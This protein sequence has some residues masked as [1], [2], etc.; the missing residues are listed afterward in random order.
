MFWKRNRLFHFDND[1]RDYC[2]D[3]KTYF[4]VG[5][6]RIYIT[7]KS[8]TINK[9]RNVKDRLKTKK[10]KHQLRD[11]KYKDKNILKNIDTI[12]KIKKKF[13]EGLISEDNIILFCIGLYQFTRPCNL[14]ESHYYQESLR[15]GRIK[16]LGIYLERF[17][18]NF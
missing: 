6:D 11:V 3:N 18:K 17:L 16:M 7:K 2:H 9:I 8:D 15:V 1:L 5:G 12:Y 10:G 4:S 13:E 14:E